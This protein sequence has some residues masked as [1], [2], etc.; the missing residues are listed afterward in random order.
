MNF[1][2]NGNHC[3]GMALG[4]EGWVYCDCECHRE[5]KK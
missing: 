4:P 3:M 1:C 5:D 2:R